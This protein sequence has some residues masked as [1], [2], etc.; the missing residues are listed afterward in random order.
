MDLMGNDCSGIAPFWIENYVQRWYCQNCDS[1]NII[2]DQLQRK[3]YI[4]INNQLTVTYNAPMRVFS[5]TVQHKPT[6][7]P[8]PEL[9]MPST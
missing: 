8:T 3:V 1:M 6:Q 4:V 5:M 7:Y 9:F 2:I